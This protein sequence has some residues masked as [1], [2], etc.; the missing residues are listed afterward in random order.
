MLARATASE[1]YKSLYQPRWSVGGTP[2]HIAVIL[3]YQDGC[4]VV[5][6]EPSGSGEPFIQ[7][8]HRFMESDHNP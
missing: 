8:S 7:D 6:P 3:N 1:H 2:P 5:T 4:H